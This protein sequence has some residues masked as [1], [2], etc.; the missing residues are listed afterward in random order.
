M[1]KV[2]PIRR[3]NNAVEVLKKIA[4]AAAYL[5]LALIVFVA[6][7]FEFSLGKEGY[8]LRIRS[9]IIKHTYYGVFFKEAFEVWEIKKNEDGSSQAAQLFPR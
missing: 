1:A 4:G 5:I 9:R 3:L 7:W 2:T 8:D 6:C